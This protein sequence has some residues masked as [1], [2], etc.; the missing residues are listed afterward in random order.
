MQYF[1]S[2]KGEKYESQ[3]QAP[4][5]ARRVAPGANNKMATSSERAKQLTTVFRTFSARLDL[6]S[7]IQGRRASLCSALALAVIFRAFGAVDIGFDSKAK[8]E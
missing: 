7:V 4:S 6:F 5:N 2:A 3:G 8:L 1:R